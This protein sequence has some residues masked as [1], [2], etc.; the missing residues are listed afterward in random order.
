M[1]CVVW[2]HIFPPISKISL[3]VKCGRYYDYYGLNFF[4]RPAEIRRHNVEDC[5]EVAI[6]EES[7]RKRYRVCKEGVANVHDEERKGR[8]SLVISDQKENVNAKIRIRK[9]TNHSSST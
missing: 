4:V 5:V 6:N 8:P 2:C 3:P 1:Y 9:Q 7:V